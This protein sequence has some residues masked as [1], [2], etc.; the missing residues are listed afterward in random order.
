MR[1]KGLRVA[2]DGPHR[3]GLAGPHRHPARSRRRVRFHVEHAHLVWLLGFHRGHVQHVD[4]QQLAEGGVQRVEHTCLVERR[5]HR[6]CDAV[7]S[8]QAACLVARELIEVRVRKQ[9]TETAVDLIEKGGLCRRHLAAA[10]RLI[11]GAA[12]Q[13]ALVLDRDPDGELRLASDTGSL[14]YL[15][16][17]GVERNDLGA[18]VCVLPGEH[19]VAQ[20]TAP[21]VLENARVHRKRVVP[22][23]ALEHV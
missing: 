10:I 13:L 6:P 14:A 21:Y 23:L 17:L 4:G 3:C 18:R 5:R 9:D 1:E 11:D 12:D 20:G 16:A 19:G 22:A 2:N 15:L 7:E 8:L